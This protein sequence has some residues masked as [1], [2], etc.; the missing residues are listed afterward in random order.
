MGAGKSVLGR[1]LS[2]KL[3]AQLIDLDNYIEA[4]EGRS[5]PEIFAQSG[6]TCFRAL[7]AEALRRISTANIGNKLQIISTG[8][9]TPC[10]EGNMQWMNQKGTT[11]WLNPPLH[12]LVERLETSKK[13]RPLLEDMDRAAKES[14]IEQLLAQRTPFYAQATVEIKTLSDKALMDIME[15]IAEKK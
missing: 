14:Y 9:G 8:G 11:I 6:E 12:V 3:R 5:I 4:C 13:T 10:F 1:R 15:W 2:R 7:E